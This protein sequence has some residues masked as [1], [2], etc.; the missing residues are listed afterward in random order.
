MLAVGSVAGLGG[1]CEVQ[2]TEQE[3][4]SNKSDNENSN[5]NNNAW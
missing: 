4:G 5:S 2:I 1:T 3:Q